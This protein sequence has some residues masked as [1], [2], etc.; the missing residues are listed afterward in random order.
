MDLEA[1]YLKLPTFAQNWACTLEGFRILRNRYNAEFRTLLREAEERTFWPADRIIEFRN[2]RLANFVRHCAETIPYYRRHFREWGIAP[3]QVRSLEDLK[4]IP[5][6]TKAEIQEHYQELLSEAVPPSQRIIAH[7]SGTTGGG[8]RF[9]TTLRAHREQWAVWWRYRR[10][11]GIDLGTPCG[12]FGGRSIVPPSQS[13]PPFWRYDHV[14]HQILF[15][16]YHMS[17]DTLPFYIQELRRRQPP[18]LNGYPSLLALLAAY[19]VENG[20]DLGYQPRWITVVAESLLPQQSQIIEKAFG[21]RPKQHYGMAEAVANVSECE[22]GRLHV[23]EDFAAVEFLPTDEPGVY[24]VVGTAFSNPAVGFLRYDVQDRVTLDEQPCP[25]GR[26]GRVVASLDGRQE[27]YVI[28]KNG[29]RVGRMDHIF[30]DLINIREAQIYQRRPG[31]VIFR[32]VRGTHYSEEDER[33]LRAEAVKRLGTDTTIVIEYVQ[34][35]TRGPTGKL[36][37][38]VSEIPEG[39]LLQSVEAKRI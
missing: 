8:L 21:V 36:R 29:A 31:E 10:W 9:A 28:L 16:G 19:I 33:R 1:V 24:R 4:S 35:L 37:F 5:V 3:D 38:V 32:V 20:I 27:D 25:C 26:P 34:S 17:P 13:K 30:K 18:W 6:L 7:T 12:Y 23:D 15:S 22:L 39:K 2:R 14:R 11:H